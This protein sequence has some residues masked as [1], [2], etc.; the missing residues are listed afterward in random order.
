MTLHIVTEVDL[1][2]TFN[3]AEAH[4]SVSLGQSHLERCMADNPADP[5]Q[6]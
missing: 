3:K 4:S 5:M 1:C 2:H 6:K